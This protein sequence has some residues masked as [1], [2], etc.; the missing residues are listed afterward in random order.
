V[1][2]SGPRPEDFHASSKLRGFQ[3]KLRQ[4]RHCAGC[5]FGRSRLACLA[6]VRTLPLRTLLEIL[7]QFLSTLNVLGSINPIESMPRPGR[8]LTMLLVYCHQ[9]NVRGR[10]QPAESSLGSIR[11]RDFPHSGCLLSTLAHSLVPQPFC[12]CRRRSPWQ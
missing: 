10:L 11:A 12:C 5:Q 3:S 4:R 2:E 8:C 9:I 1:V 7:F 6:S